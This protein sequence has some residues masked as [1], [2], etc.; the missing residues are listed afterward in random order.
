M[1]FLNEAKAQSS[2]EA[3]Q[4]R[5]GGSERGRKATRPPNMP[6]GKYRIETEAPPSET[7]QGV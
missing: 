7:P 6:G 3:M 2:H 1:E 5:N 4:S